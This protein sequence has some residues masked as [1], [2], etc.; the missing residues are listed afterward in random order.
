MRSTRMAPYVPLVV[1]AARDSD[2]E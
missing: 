2:R 1:W